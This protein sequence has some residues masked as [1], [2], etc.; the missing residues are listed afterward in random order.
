MEPVIRDLADTARWVAHYRAEESERDD[1]V[2]RD[3]LARRLACRRAA[4]GLPKR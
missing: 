1:A 2:F 3:P 4:A